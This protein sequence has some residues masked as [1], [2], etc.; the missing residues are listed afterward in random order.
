V[1]KVTKGAQ[2]AA[3]FEIPAGYNKFERD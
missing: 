1:Q 3:L 2:K